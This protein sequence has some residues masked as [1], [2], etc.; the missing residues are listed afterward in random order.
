MFLYEMWKFM[1]Q[2]KGRT[3]YSANLMA[4]NNFKA[5]CFY[6]MSIL[7]Q[8][9][10]VFYDY[11]STTFHIT[12]AAAVSKTEHM[13]ACKTANNGFQIVWAVRYC[14]GAH[15]SAQ[16]VMIGCSKGRSYD[17]I[18]PNISLSITS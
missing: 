7:L 10:K 17:T 14:T 6:F 1:L 5:Q 18:Y 11:Y 3:K 15:L 4:I 2:K 8:E 16:A 13:L 12:C 9:R